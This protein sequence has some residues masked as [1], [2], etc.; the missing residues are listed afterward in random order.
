MRKRRIVLLGLLSLAAIPASAPAQTPYPSRPISIIVPY[1][2]G[3]GIDIMG[4]AIA[5]NL[6]AR[7]ATGAVVDNKPGASGNI[8]TELVANAAPDGHT[9]LMT[10][11]TFATNAAINKNL[12]YDPAKG[13]VPISLAATGTMAF[14]TSLNTPAQTVQEFV[15]LA[16]SRPGA[17]SYASNGNGTPQHLAM[18]LFKLETGIDVTHVPYK[19]AGY[20]SDVIGGRIDAVIMPIHT[21]APYVH[22]GKMRMLAVMSAERSPVFPSVPTF[23]EAGFANLQV[24]VWYGL[25]APAGTPVEITARLNAEVNAMLAQPEVR[26]LLG[27]QGLTPMGGPPARLGDL[28]KL[29]LERWPRVVANA[30][31]KP[32]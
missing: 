11:T 6:S 32:D 5:Q 14:F 31:I 15:S 7:W 25:L 9:L 1:S 3:T 23:R 24:D 21:A 16:R 10:A 27:R 4:R 20:I 12:R 28:V 2:P 17:L 19:S 30:G 18:E 29:E 22:G 8:G 26:E 13:F